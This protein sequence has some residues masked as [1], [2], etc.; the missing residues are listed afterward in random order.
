VRN[1]IQTGQVAGLADFYT[2]S[3]GAAVA[4][5]ARQA[6]FPNPGIYAADLIHNGGFSDYHAMQ[7]ELRRELRGGLFGQINYTRA[8]TRSNSAGTAQTRFEPFLDNARPELDE[9]R[10]QFHVSHV[11]N[12][13]MIAELPFGR[14]RRWLN[15]DGIWDYLAGGWQASAIVH[16]QAGSPISLLARRGTFNRS[17]RSFNQTARTTL[18]AAEIGDLLGVT[19]ADGKMYWIDPKVID[20]STGRGVGADNLTNA[21]GFNGQVF[22]NPMAGEV[23]DLEILAFEGPRQFLVDLSF[24]KR[25]R[26]FREMGLQFRADVFNL[27]N[28]VNFDVGDYDIN[29]TTFGQI[30]N[31]N[32]GARVVQLVLKLDF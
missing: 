12:A 24:S 15:K 1:L 3:A 31:T 20:S 25:V 6:F 16:W 13:N 21:S 22:F 11:I 7:L 2:T 14:G 4:A 18:T 30:T 32:T 23:G 17:D 5:Q 8:N 10:S 28:T 9:G 27:F 19:E 29:S 26:L